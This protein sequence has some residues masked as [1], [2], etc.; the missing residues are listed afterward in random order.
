MVKKK[1][2]ILG[3]TFFFLVFV[4]YGHKITMVPFVSSTAPVLFVGVSVSRSLRHGDVLC[5]PGNILGKTIV[6]F[7]Y[8]IISNTPFGGPSPFFFFFFFLL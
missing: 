5:A 3:H 6:N 2:S 7:G 8:R 4:L 1:R